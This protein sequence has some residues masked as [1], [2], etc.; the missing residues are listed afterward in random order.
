[1]NGLGFPWPSLLEHMADQ[2]MARFIGLQTPRAGT[3][4][5]RTVAWRTAM[6]PDTVP[7]TPGRPSATALAGLTAA[8]IVGAVIPALAGLAFLVSLATRRPLIGGAA[9]HWPWLTSYPPGDLPRRVQVGL[10][11]V[12]GIGLLAAGARP[13]GQR[14]HR[15]PDHQQPRQ[16]HHPGADRPGRRSR[17]GRHHHYLAA[18]HASVTE[19]YEA[20]TRA[21]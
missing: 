16:L 11:A 7:A 6:H 19:Q 21:L 20:D 14:D 13:G 4:P 1:M 10:T 2:A 12:W 9:R 17:P 18:P 15:R 8:A 3:R 5:D